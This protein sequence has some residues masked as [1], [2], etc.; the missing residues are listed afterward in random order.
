MAA[1]SGQITVTTAG[2]EVQG[3]DVSS[4]S[5]PILIVALSSNT[6]KIYVGNDGSNAVSSTTGYEL[7]AGNNIATFGNLNQ[8]WFDSSVNGEKVAWFVTD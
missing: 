4:N 3:P 7:S 5:K 2:T 1:K 8:L 6:G